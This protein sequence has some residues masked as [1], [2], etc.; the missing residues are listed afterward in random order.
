MKL[1]FNPE[2]KMINKFMTSTNKIFI[3]FWILGPLTVST[4]TVFN[5]IFYLYNRLH[6]QSYCFFFFYYYWIITNIR[7]RKV[8]FKTGGLFFFRQSVLCKKQSTC[9]LIINLNQC[10]GSLRFLVLVLHIT[11]SIVGIFHFDFFT[12]FCV[13]VCTRIKK[14]NTIPYF[15]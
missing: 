11:H 12:T 13:C 1:N 5:F 6:F 3:Y 15:H 7:Q 9:R 14:R 8:V 10:V 2:T 4:I